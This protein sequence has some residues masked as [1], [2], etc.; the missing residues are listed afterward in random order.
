MFNFKKVINRKLND[1][2]INK[3][4][5]GEY[6]YWFLHNSIERIDLFIILSNEIDSERH[7][8]SY[9]KSSFRGS[10]LTTS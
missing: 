3:L 1:G 6:E 9:G 5:Q 10:N 7:V 4:N 2:K 8:R